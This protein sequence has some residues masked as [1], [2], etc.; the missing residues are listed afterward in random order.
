MQPKRVEVHAS[1]TGK[2]RLLALNSIAAIATV[3][4]G[5]WAESTRDWTDIGRGD[6]IQALA[7]SNLVVHTIRASERQPGA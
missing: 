2:G 1:Q 5:T 3:L 4:A 7:A 6:R